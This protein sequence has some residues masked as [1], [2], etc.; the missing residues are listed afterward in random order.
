MSNPLT[1]SGPP[2]I[3]LVASGLVD[4][5]STEPLVAVIPHATQS[6][7]YLLLIHLYIPDGPT[8]K[9]NA[10]FNT[11]QQILTDAGELFL[12]LI[13]IDYIRPPRGT[14]TYSL[15][16]IRVEYT[17]EGPGAEAL[18][19][20]IFHPIDSDPVTSRGTVTSVAT[21]FKI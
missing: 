6:N 1:V 14:T 8:P 12:R 18:W 9:L 13:S 3:N 21:T 2:A 17:V 19:V 11:I 15:W 7:S 20:K 10:D 16:K 4:Y 5:F